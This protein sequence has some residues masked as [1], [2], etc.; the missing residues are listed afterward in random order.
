[1]SNSNKEPELGKNSQLKASNATTPNTG[2]SVQNV[3]DVQTKTSNTEISDGTN[4][5][6]QPTPAQNTNNS[7][8]AEPNTYKYV[9]PQGGNDAQKNKKRWGCGGFLRIFIS[10]LLTITVPLLLCV[11]PF[12]SLIL[13]SSFNSNLLEPTTG[14]EESRITTVGSDEEDAETAEIAV[15]NVNGVITYSTPGTDTVEVGS[16]SNNIIN[17]LDKAD[18]DDNVEAILMHYNSP[19]GEVSASEPICSKIKEVNKNKPVYSFIDTT[20]ASLAYL[21]PNCGEEIYARE[22]AITGSIGVVIQAIDFLGIL[23]N[24]GGKVIFITNTQGDQKTGEDIFEEGSETYKRYQAILDET[25]EYFLNVVLEGRDGKVSREEL[26]QYADGSIFSG[27]QA[28]DIGL[29]DNISEFES[30]LEDIADK[31]PELEG[32]K[33]DVIRYS[34]PQNPFS[35][36]FGATMNAINGF[37]LKEEIEQSGEIKLMYK[38]RPNLSNTSP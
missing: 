33:V 37:D 21:L 19:G 32:K 24:V 12:F 15:I 25:Y 20:G 28:A 1:M 4:N 23:E 2:N 17:Q 14:I 34:L 10:I 9:P 22:S 11:A 18:R 38:M 26:L 7:N 16:T 31:V 30:T 5:M 35:Q 3:Q 27:Q 6:N 13:L 29:V 8:S 36:L